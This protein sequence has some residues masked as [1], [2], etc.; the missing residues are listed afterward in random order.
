MADGVAVP[1]GKQTFQD[2]DTGALLVGGFVYHYIPTTDTP[3]DTWADEG[4]TVLNTNPV[5]LDGAG[6]CVIWGEGLYRQV[7]TDSLGNQIWDKVTGYN[8]TPMNFATADEVAALARGD[9]AISP[10]ALGDSGVLGGSGGGGFYP[11]LT[12]FGAIADGVVGS[13][14]VGTNNAPYIDAS[15]AD[16]SSRIWISDGVFRTSE[17]TGFLYKYFDGPGKIYDSLTGETLPGRFTYL[18]TPPAQYPTQ[19][20]LGWFAGNTSYT[21]PE[22]FV[23]G[24]NCRHAIGDRYFE[25][26]TIP[27]NRWFTSFGG[28]SGTIAHLAS[29]A[30]IGAGTATLN[31]TSGLAVGN[32]VGFTATAGLAFTDTVTLT[33]VNAGTGVI[34]FTPVLTT[35]YSVGAVVTLS[36]RTNNPFRYLQGRNFAAGDFVSD[37][38]RC[39]Q[40]Y[41][42]LAGQTHFFETSTVSQ[43]GG[44][45]GFYTDGCYATVIESQLIDN[46]FD[47]AAIADVESFVRDNDTGARSAVWLG[48]FFKSEGAKP[49]DAAHVIAGKWRI[50]IDTTKADLTTFVTPGD[51]LNCAFNTKLG[52]R[53]IMNSTASNA[54]RGGSAT[55]GTFFGN[56]PGDMYIE[57]GT[58]GTSDFIALRFNRAG[59]NDGRLRL[60]PNAVQ[61]NVSIF[62]AKT[63]EA[64]QELV[65]GGDSSTG[66]PTVVYGPGLG[67]WIEWNGTN[68]RAT[69]DGGS[70]FTNI[71]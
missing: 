1:A 69:K 40:H 18:Q 65:T 42:A 32:V 68:L 45:I 13:P 48:T 36:A 62:S 37:L 5:Q 17:A 58:D 46:G 12:S 14:G 28:S 3:K 22:Y 60:R 7:L 11:K 54:A 56:V 71:V 53:W 57:S 31:S 49:A 51:N 9:V 33:N 55:Y 23:I 4:L 19:G 63:V 16:P 30:S 2:P 39:Q 8:G 41:V 66:R 52:H 29:I 6:Q 15:V 20:V 70:T 47:V 10:L 34:S 25:A 59:P 44:D 26:T 64:T 43:Y 38:S 24:A 21:E 35:G 67:V 61:A 27:H 50:A